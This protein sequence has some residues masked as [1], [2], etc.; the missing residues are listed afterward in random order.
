MK[1]SKSE[2]HK[3]L[4]MDWE[5]AINPENDYLYDYYNAPSWLPVRDRIHELGLDE[6][7]KVKDLDR[8]AIINAIKLNADMPYERDYDDLKRWW[9]H[10]EK[11]ADG[12]YPAELLPEHLREVYIEALNQYFRDLCKN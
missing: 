7:E 1:T 10:L 4:I 6:D 2:E 5:F 8:L 11:I 12:T 3:E 9:W